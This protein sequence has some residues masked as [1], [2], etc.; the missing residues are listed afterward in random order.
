MQKLMDKPLLYFLP[1]IIPENSLTIYLKKKMCVLCRNAKDIVDTCEG[2][3]DEA[4]MDADRPYALIH[5]NG[6]N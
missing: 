3:L 6:R 1:V 2:A 4:L 5:K